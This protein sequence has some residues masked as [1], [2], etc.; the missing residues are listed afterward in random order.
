M[1]SLRARE[2]TF[3]QGWSH[4]CLQPS[5]LAEAG[6]HFTPLN[7][8]D[9]TTTCF[10]CEKS[11][12]G[13]E[14]GDDPLLEHVKHSS[15]CWWAL[16]MMQQRTPTLAPQGP[17]MTAAREASFMGWPYEKKRGWL[18]KAKKMAKAGWHYAP[19]EESQDAV[20][21]LYCSTELDGWEPKDDP[22]KEHEKRA[23]DLQCAF[24]TGLVDT[25]AVV[26]DT[27]AVKG[28]VVADKVS[29]TR[30]GRNNSVTTIQSDTTDVSTIA[31]IA[32]AEAS[33]KRQKGGKRKL[34]KSKTRLDQDI[35]PEP[36]IEV[37]DE[38][39]SAAAKA[40]IP[41]VLQSARKKRKSD[42]AFLSSDKAAVNGDAETHSPSAKRQCNQAGPVRRSRRSGST[43]GLSLFAQ[44]LLS[45]EPELSVVSQPSSTRKRAVRSSSKT[46]GR[47]GRKALEDLEEDVAGPIIVDAIEEHVEEEPVMAKSQGKKK[48]KIIEEDA[49]NPVLAEVAPLKPATSLPERRRSTRRSS[50]N[51]TQQ[52]SISIK[53]ETSFSAATLP[54]LE[55]E[56]VQSPK[57]SQQTQ[58]RQSRSSTRQSLTAE[59][60]ASLTSLGPSKR[61][62][63]AQ[64]RSS[65]RRGSG[66]TMGSLFLEDILSSTRHGGFSSQ[67]IAQPV[68]LEEEKEVGDMSEMPL[69]PSRLTTKPARKRTSRMVASSV[70][71]QEE[72][73]DSGNSSFASAYSSLSTQPAFVDQTSAPPAAAKRRPS[74]GASQVAKKII[75]Q[76][77]DEEEERKKPVQ[78]AVERV[79]RRAS[80]ASST[81][82]QVFVDASSQFPPQETVPTA[83]ETVIEVIAEECEDVVAK[84]AP[85][86]RKVKGAAK[87]KVPKKRSSVPT[88]P[89][90]VVEAD[91]IREPA[92]PVSLPSL[93]EAE[94][95]PLAVTSPAPVIPET[96]S[97][98]HPLSQLAQSN[99]K[100]VYGTPE[101]GS[102]LPSEEVILPAK[103]PAKRRKGRVIQSLSTTEEVGLPL[104]EPVDEIIP[105]PVCAPKTKRGSGISKGAPIVRRTS[106]RRGSSNAGGTT[107]EEIVGAVM[108]DSKGKSRLQRIKKK[109]V[110]A[111]PVMLEE[112]VPEELEARQ[113][114]KEEASLAVLVP[115]V[116]ATAT[117][118]PAEEVVKEVS[119]VCEDIALS[120][121]A[122]DIIMEEEEEQEVPTTPVKPTP[123][124]IQ[125]TPIQPSAWTDIPRDLYDASTMLQ[126]EQIC[127]LGDL[128]ATERDMTVEHW[129]RF[130]A[131]READ[132]LTD[133]C[134]AMV[135]RL[136][137]GGRLA[138]LAIEAMP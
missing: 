17:Q 109:P 105:A 91:A 45:P 133:A 99:V 78:T 21:C 59:P 53:Q 112:V 11:L 33:V 138:R 87:V 25:A 82:P 62:S 44:A 103:Q 8:G 70:V 106:S 86:A 69:A 61:S 51:A 117:T 6:F 122:A 20:A 24:F 80:R 65:T 77:S 13:W 102:S 101:P 124:M 9:D 43:S 76:L 18:I 135:T 58:R 22:L 54:A 114:D 90:Q 120:S 130:I 72:D 132:K 41:I 46:R 98:T 111:E 113:P 96:I 50:V 32:I 71:L 118:E 134:E 89:L 116:E 52:A 38:A 40:A 16:L 10:A 127:Q 34:L 125:G 93:A 28:P 94:L 63:S 85:V 37:D 35:V 57:K 123:T 119:P 95:E 97:P 66:A 137:E 129:I 79:R 2:L 26:Q 29:T 4:A 3:D 74:R 55:E 1:Q 104:Q 110:V 88:A 30:R 64:R 48:K 131:R 60:V 42:V 47:T 92:D 68:V 14:A 39:V 128:S 19:S 84:K 75:E 107:L 12:G 83:S 73:L 7:P 5:I 100:I 36:V 115:D 67:P 31:S 49:F 126:P 108:L 27:A 121:V 81:V 56:A 23:R 15:A 136:A